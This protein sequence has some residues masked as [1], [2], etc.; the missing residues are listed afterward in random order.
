MA[1]SRLANAASSLPAELLALIYG[2]LPRRSL[3]S[4][5]GVSSWWRS[6]ATQDP[7]Y[8]RPW[9]VKFPARKKRARSR[10]PKSTDLD[11]LAHVIEDSEAR[12]YPLGLRVSIDLVNHSSSASDEVIERN[13]SLFRDVLV[14][15]LR[16]ALARV[17]VLELYIC[18]YSAMLLWDGLTVPAPL[19]R[20]LTIRV[21]TYN[22]DECPEAPPYPRHFLDETAPRLT[23]V[24]LSHVSLAAAPGVFPSV[25]RLELSYSSSVPD[26]RSATASYPNLLELVIKDLPRR[27]HAA[28]S[29]NHSALPSGLRVLRLGPGPVG[30][31]VGAWPSGV[32]IP[33]IEYNSSGLHD[34]LRFLRFTEPVSVHIF[35]HLRDD[36]AEEL[37]PTRSSQLCLEVASQNAVRR[38]DSD[39]RL[40][41]TIG[42]LGQSACTAHV[43]Q[44]TI[45]D[46]HVRS[47]IEA[48]DCMPALSALSIILVVW[49]TLASDAHRTED[50]ATLYSV[51]HVRNDCNCLGGPFSDWHD[52]GPPDGDCRPEWPALQS[53]ELRATR[54]SSTVSGDLLRGLADALTPAPNRLL[55]LELTNGL[56]LADDAQGPD[57]AARFSEIRTGF[58]ASLECVERAAA[59]LAVAAVKKVDARRTM[60]QMLRFE[61]PD[62]HWEE[63][64]QAT[65]GRESGSDSD[66]RSRSVSSLI[67]GW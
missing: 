62:F 60:T 1:P 11:K 30:P 25:R 66:S 16:R 26:L 12:G 5:A 64:E 50:E 33:F 59:L 14:P 54:A 27:G 35:E 57:T 41:D 56:V 44:L 38:V 63:C 34:A 15:T 29:P 20:T 21:G 39:A 19:M 23:D 43:T 48:C 55:A 17:A 13:K 24:S 58:C 67:A 8:Y 2:M 36:E 31:L 65:S 61:G 6:N 28:I 37:D 22:P 53:L 3:L 18:A 47:L 42:L 51:Y 49:H 45:D 9:T 4:A 40:M 52:G 32:D 46:R 10:A 7:K